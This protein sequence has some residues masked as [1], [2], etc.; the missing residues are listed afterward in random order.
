[1]YFEMGKRMDISQ[2]EGKWMADMHTKWYSISLVI[3]EIQI[4]TAVRYHFSPTI[5]AKIKDWQ[6]KCGQVELKY[7]AGWMQNDIAPFKNRLAMF[8]K[9]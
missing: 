1:M 8:L 5:I 4:K 7:V 6:H 2:K 3:G 9:S